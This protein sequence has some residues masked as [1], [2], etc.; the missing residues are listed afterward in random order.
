MA[1]CVFR[2]TR[3]TLE[4]TIVFWRSLFPHLC[5][6][7]WT[8]LPVSLH[9]RRGWT[10]FTR[11]SSTTG[12]VNSSTSS[13]ENTSDLGVFK[14]LVLPCCFNRRFFNIV[15]LVR[16][17]AVNKLLPQDYFHRCSWV[18]NH[19]SLLFQVTNGASLAW[20][21]FDSAYF[22]DFCVHRDQL[23]CRNLV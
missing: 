18:N 21:S 11:I 17:K 16:F 4:H 6:R 23:F 22:R 12:S 5:R 7:K 14:Y 20:N 15:Y 10:I 9:R 19:N 8:V 1:M 3:F 2:Y 13:K